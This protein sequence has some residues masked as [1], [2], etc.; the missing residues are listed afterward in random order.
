MISKHPG[1]DHRDV[2]D[3]L[4]HGVESRSEFVRLA[5][6]LLFVSFCLQLADA[7]R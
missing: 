6:A 1:R 7:E 5:R 2:V 3:V 4:S